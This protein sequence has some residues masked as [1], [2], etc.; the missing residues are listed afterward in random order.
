MNPGMQLMK[1]SELIKA[2]WVGGII[3]TGGCAVSGP[4]QS[5]HLADWPAGTA[6]AEV[7]A[8]VAANVLARQFD[9]ETNPRRKS[10]IY[11]EA[12]AWYGALTVAALT[13]D[14]N[15][16]A[17]GVARFERFLTPEGAGWV[18][19]NAHVDFRVIGIVPLEIYRQTKDA[20]C[21]A[22]G[23]TL[24]EA[25]WENPTADGLTREARYWVDDIYMIAALQTQAYR[26]TGDEKYLDR[27]ARLTV[28]Y[29]DKLQQPNGLFFHAEDSPFYWGRGCGWY[30]AGM[31]ELL[32]ELPA[33]HPQHARIL[34]GYRKMMAALLQH[35][36]AGGL[37]RQLVD[38]PESWLETSGSAMF[39]Y[40]IVTGVKRGWL[41]EASYGPAARRAWLALVAELDADANVKNVCVGTNKGFKE[42][43]AQLDQQL[44]FYLERPRKTGD[45]HG[46]APLL[47]TATALMK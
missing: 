4:V 27:A 3:L 44:K 7:G 26:A 15:L 32:S 30:A 25:Q 28:A 36:S 5:K 14:T 9:F 17:R 21:L 6:P 40:A 24:A 20:R 23:R 10:L 41:A 43:G 12:C 37:W 34:A 46:Q 38:R 16:Q 35:Q 18:S 42:V 29:L 45:L 2:L 13:G 19:T 33:D 8:R 22:L 39:T 47:W 31:T 1:L 11:P